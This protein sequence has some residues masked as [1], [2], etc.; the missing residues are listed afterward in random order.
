VKVF[1]PLST[2]LMAATLATD[3]ITA[4]NKNNKKKILPLVA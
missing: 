4:K 3:S 1:L 2:A